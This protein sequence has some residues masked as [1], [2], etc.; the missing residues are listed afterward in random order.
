MEI[1]EKVLRPAINEAIDN[2]SPDD[3]KRS[4]DIA[5]EV[6]LKSRI[7]RAFQFVGQSL[8]IESGAIIVYLLD[9]KGKYWWALQ[10]AKLDGYIP[11]FGPFDE[12]QKATAHFIVQFAVN[13]RQFVEIRPENVK[14]G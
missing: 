9:G 13:P 8:V 2:V 11:V 7:A 4:D 14:I 5:R 12:I 1:D 6:L 3:V 10:T